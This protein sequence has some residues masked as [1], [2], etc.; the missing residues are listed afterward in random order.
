MAEKRAKDRVILKLLG[1]AGDMY[2]EEEADEFKQATPQE[3]AKATR[4]VNKEIKATDL[5]IRYSDWM[6]YWKNHEWSHPANN[7]FRKFLEEA[8]DYDQ[9]KLNELVALFKT[10]APEEIND[11]LPDWA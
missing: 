2:S 8:K 5:D 1:I 10:K 3:K 4:S 6:T 9:D 7:S 11:S